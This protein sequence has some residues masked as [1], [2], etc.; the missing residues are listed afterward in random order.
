MQ[1]CP[2]DADTGDNR[3]HTAVRLRP[4]LASLAIGSMRK[5]ALSLLVQGHQTV[6][7]APIYQWQGQPVLLEMRSANLAARQYAADDTER[8]AQK[9]QDRSPQLGTTTSSSGPTSYAQHR[10][11]HPTAVLLDLAPGA[12]HG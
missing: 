10:G 1:L 12:G 7:V 6:N 4:P 2:D 8:T 5:M 11:Q 9:S 3:K